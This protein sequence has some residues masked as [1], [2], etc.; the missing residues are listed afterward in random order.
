MNKTGFLSP[1]SPDKSVT[2]VPSCAKR[3][4][5]GQRPD[6][7]QVIGHTTS[8]SI[9]NGRARR[10][11]GPPRAACR[12]AAPPA[13]NPMTS[14]LRHNGQNDVGRVKQSTTRHPS[15]DSSRRHARPAV[16]GRVE[17]SVTRQDHPS[18]RPV[19]D[20]SV[21]ASWRNALRFFRPTSRR[22]GRVTRTKAPVDR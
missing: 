4:A 3:V 1:M 20:Q 14:I 7:V 10:T 11:P 21:G 19:S 13:R 16:V 18:R 15:R 5:L 12:C 22:S 17:R 9:R 6:A 8:M 2:H